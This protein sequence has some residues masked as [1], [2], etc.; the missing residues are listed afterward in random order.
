MSLVTP[1][2]IRNRFR[3]DSKNRIAARAELTPQ[4]LSRGSG[5]SSSEIQMEEN[6]LC[7]ASHH[8]AVGPGPL[9]SAHH[10]ERAVAQPLEQLQL[11]LPDQAGE[12]GGRLAAAAA[13]VQ[14][15]ADGRRRRRRPMGEGL[16]GVGVGALHRK[17]LQQDANGKKHGLLP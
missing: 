14:G 11:R 1:L 9:S 6:P 12:G 15:L 3:R 10:A 17:H 8:S 13:A 4:T 16:L 7:R 5:I 2:E